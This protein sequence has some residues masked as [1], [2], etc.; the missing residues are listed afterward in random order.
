MGSIIPKELRALID[1]LMEERAGAVLQAELLAEQEARERL[2]Q[3]YP[4]ATPNDDLVSLKWGP[5]LDEGHTMTRAEASEMLHSFFTL[6]PGNAATEQRPRV[7]GMWRGGETL[8]NIWFEGH[9]SS[10][11]MDQTALLQ[12]L[13]E[14]DKA[15]Q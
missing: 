8:F 11:D 7:V 4:T 10:P 3:A 9:A 6:G 14:I 15:V 12:F 1:K 2:T 13:T 5:G